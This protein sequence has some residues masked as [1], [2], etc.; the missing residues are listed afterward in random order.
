MAVP[1]CP[2]CRNTGFGYTYNNGAVGYLI[3]CNSC[4]C[5]VGFV[6]VDTRNFAVGALNNA[7]WVCEHFHLQRIQA[8]P[9]RR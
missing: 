6:D 4:G 8:T 9:Q 2:R 7:G 1:N 3:H 5:V